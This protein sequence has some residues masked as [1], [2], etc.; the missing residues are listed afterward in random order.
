MYLAQDI[1]LPLQSS[2]VM[3]FLYQFDDYIRFFVEIVFN[4]ISA[5]HRSPVPRNGGPMRDSC[6]NSP[7]G[8]NSF[9]FSDR[10]AQRRS[11]TATV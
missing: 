3:P 7:F 8:R 9:Q 6:R 10:I 2:L 5:K 4:G 1:R 11:R